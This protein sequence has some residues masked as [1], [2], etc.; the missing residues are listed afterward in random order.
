MKINQTLCKVERQMGK[1][2][3]KNIGVKNLNFV[4]KKSR[5]E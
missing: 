3:K 4:E 5:L 2:Y 1:G